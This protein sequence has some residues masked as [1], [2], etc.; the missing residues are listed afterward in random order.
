MFSCYLSTNGIPDVDLVIRTGDEYRLSNFMLWQTAY[1]EYY[2]TPIL[3]PD[4]DI[5][6]L[7]RA[8]ETYHQR[9]RRF[10]GD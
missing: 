2:F 9:H 7:E 3:F 8:L 1:S 6:E 4:F 10:G 5:M